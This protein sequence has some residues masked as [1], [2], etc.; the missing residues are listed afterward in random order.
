M[1]LTAYVPI[2]SIPAATPFQLQS[3]GS[4]LFFVQN[5]VCF[6]SFSF[7]TGSFVPIYGLG[8]GFNYSLDG[9]KKVFIDITVAPNLQI[10]G[11][12][13]VNDVVGGTYWPGYPNMIQIDPMDQVNEKGQVTKLIDNKK[14]TKCYILVGYGSKD[15][16]KNSISESMEISE[17]ILNSDTFPIQVLDTNIILLAS[18]VSGVPVIFPSPYLNGQSHLNGIRNTAAG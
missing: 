6:S 4:G 10:S 15:T 11:A 3:N 12:K 1:S 7:S 18:V 13:I 8:T 2:R 9:N 16:N 5:G 17:A 14:Q